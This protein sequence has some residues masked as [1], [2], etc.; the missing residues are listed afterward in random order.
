MTTT[1]KPKP[2]TYSMRKVLTNLR[3]GRPYDVGFHGRS[4]MGGLHGTILA[5]TKRG[6]LKD[7][8][9]TA[10]GRKASKCRCD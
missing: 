6:L 8:K 3:E 9:L 5:L 10:A 7:Y 4:Q 1:P 2:L